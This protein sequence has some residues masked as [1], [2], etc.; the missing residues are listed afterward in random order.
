MKI[1]EKIAET[2]FPS[3]IYCICCGNIIDDTRPYALCD[4]CVEK[5]HWVGKKTCVKCGKLLEDDCRYELCY[6]CMNTEHSF[7]KGFTCVQYGLHERAVMM[8]Y[9]YKGR[10]YIGKKL[11]DMMY[12]RLQLEDIDFDMIVP[13]P[14]HAKKEAERGFNQ[15]QVMADR[16]AKLSGKPCHTKLLLRKKKTVPMRDLSVSERMENVEDAFGIQ[17][18]GGE[19]LK[20]KRV[21]LIDDIYTTGSTMD[22]CSR[23]LREEGAVRVYAFSFAA[24]GNRKNQIM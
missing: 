19:M 20:G 2:L 13:V 16:L 5:F 10:S 18:G 9:K 4:I 3:N 6:D 8:D 17:K 12:D 7:D 22:S 23:V 15:A 11:G 14:I 1:T 21:L 24:G